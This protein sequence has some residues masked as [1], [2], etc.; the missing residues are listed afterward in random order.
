MRRRQEG[1]RKRLEEATL[2]A[3]KTEEGAVSQGTWVPPEAGKRKKQAPR[4][5]EGLCILTF[6]TIRS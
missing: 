2:R 3:L 4:V 5:S 6:R 1:H